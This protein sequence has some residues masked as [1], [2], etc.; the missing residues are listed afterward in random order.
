MHSIA[1]L[2]SLISLILV[3]IFSHILLAE[4]IPSESGIIYGVAA[5]QRLTMDYYAGQG[6]GP[7][8][9]VILVH[10]GGFVAGDSRSSSEIYCADFLV[11]AGYAVFSINYRLAPEFFYPAP[12]QDVERAIRF[13]RANAGRWDVDPARLALVGGSAGGYIGAMAGLEQELGN[14]AASDPVERASARVQ[15]VVSLYGLTGFEDGKLSKNEHLLLDHLIRQK[16]KA[17][18]LREASPAHLVSK[19]SPPFLQ[20]IGD[21]DEYF[22]L[23]SVTGFDEKL[24]AAGVSSTVIVIPGGSHG[25]YDWHRLP[26]VPDWERRMTEWLNAE[27][28]H[29]GPIGEGIRRR[30]PVAE[31]SSSR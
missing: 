28:S 9:A 21:K 23:S 20:I 14:E 10:S 5:R 26:N 13:V 29:S 3:A 22:G 17:A 6:A 7:H 8:P 18:A 16:G 27:L 1:R 4:R 25:T 19:T 11:P 12:I 31:A 30:E 2:R 24:R 15:A